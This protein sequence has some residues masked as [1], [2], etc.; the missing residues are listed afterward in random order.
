MAGTLAAA[1]QCAQA[2]E[3][4]RAAQ[5]LLERQL[6]PA[7]TLRSYVAALV[8]APDCRVAAGDARLE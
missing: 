2:R 1:G 6:L 8:A 3:Q 7:S 5:P 4:A